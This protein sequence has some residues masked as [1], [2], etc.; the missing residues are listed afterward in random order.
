MLRKS[1]T[2]ARVTPAIRNTH[3]LLLSLDQKVP[4]SSWHTCNG[5]KSEAIIDPVWIFSRASSRVK[6]SYSLLKW[7]A[8]DL[9]VNLTSFGLTCTIWYKRPVS[10]S[11]DQ[12]MILPLFSLAQPRLFIPCNPQF[13][14]K[15]MESTNRKEQAGKATRMHA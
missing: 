14:S 12:R 13:C 9:W 3:N 6:R 4:L 1:F 11:L 2:A 7:L 8:I 5:G 10:S 15:F